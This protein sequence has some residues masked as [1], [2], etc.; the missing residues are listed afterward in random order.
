MQERG[1][2][3]PARPG[4]CWPTVATVLDCKGRPRLSSLGQSPVSH[5]VSDGI[6]QFKPRQGGPLG[7]FNN[8][9]NRDSRCRA[10]Q[11]FR[12]QW[13]S[14]VILQILPRAPGIVESCRL[15]G[16]AYPTVFIQYTCRCK[17]RRC[18]DNVR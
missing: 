16:R 5:D 3:G 7:P 14:R 15:G 1:S 17:V 8:R 12:P 18:R 10:V 9:R 11:L 2:S 4:N 6:L 13:Q